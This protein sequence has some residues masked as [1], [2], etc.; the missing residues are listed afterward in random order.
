M[1]SFSKA[2]ASARKGGKST[3]TWNGKSYNTKLAKGGTAPK[4][5]PVP[6]KKPST[7]KA[8]ATTSS[9]KATGA[10][11]GPVPMKDVGIAR[12]GSAISKAKAR[13]DNA[14]VTPVKRTGLALRGEQIMA[15]A[16][17]RKGAAEKAASKQGPQP[18]GVWY[19]RKGSPM[20]IG[21]A[22]RANKPV[23]K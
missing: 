3:F 16:K 22:R 4:N 2:F 20:S 1:A 8:T 23:K 6:G 10:K 18:E 11:A 19:A 12:K 15:G 7:V 14:P 13:M 5:V 17:V 21:A 9:V